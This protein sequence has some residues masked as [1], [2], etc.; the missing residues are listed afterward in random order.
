MSANPCP[1]SAVVVGLA[2]YAHVADVL[3]SLEFYERL[4]LARGNTVK[5]ADGRVVW[6][7]ARRGSAH[8]MF[9]LASG[10]VVPEQQAVLFYLYTEDLALLRRHLV[11]TGVVEMSALPAPG[12]PTSEP[13][14][15][16][17][18]ITHPFYM[19]K[20]ECRVVDPDGYS[21]LIGQLDD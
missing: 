9:A 6:G 18:P 16:V 17:Y 14:G 7:S 2:P 19:P 20:G 5:S 12:H 15:R 10:V 21:L 13:R 4:G 3:R 8:I 1:P 11:A